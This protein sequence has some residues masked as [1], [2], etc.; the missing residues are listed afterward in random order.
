MYVLILPPF[1]KVSLLHIC[2]TPSSDPLAA[3]TLIVKRARFTTFYPYLTPRRTSC[4]HYLK[5]GWARME[6]FLPNASQQLIRRMVRG[7]DTP[8]LVCTLHV[9]GPHS[10]S[11]LSPLLCGFMGCRYNAMWVQKE[12]SV[13]AVHVLGE[14]KSREHAVGCEGHWCATSV[15]RKQGCV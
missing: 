8:C 10:G 3:S 12:T 14:K 11:V 4:R 1:R 7:S 5:P 9:C 6:C 2:R 15:A 13:E